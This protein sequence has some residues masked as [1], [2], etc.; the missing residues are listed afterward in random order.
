MLYKDIGRRLFNAP[1]ANGFCDGA[2]STQNTLSNGVD[3][4]VDD[5]HKSG[6]KC[7]ECWHHGFLLG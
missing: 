4:P 3:G 5:T 1:P 6:K 7:V 2:C